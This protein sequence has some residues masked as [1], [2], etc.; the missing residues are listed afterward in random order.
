M[1]ICYIYC[2]MCMHAK[3]LQSCLTLCDPRDCS[4][5][6]SSVHRVLQARILEWV[7][8]S[9]SLLYILL[10]I[11]YSSKTLR[12]Y[13]PVEMGIFNSPIHNQNKLLQAESV[14]YVVQYPMQGRCRAKINTLSV[15]SCINLKLHPQILLSLPF[16]RL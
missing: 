14:F 6:G 10:Y 16:S 12:L 5:P 3:L 13:T 2:Y 15:E 1:L 7:A 9:F 4:L 11:S 8:I